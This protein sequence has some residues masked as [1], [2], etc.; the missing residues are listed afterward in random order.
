MNRLTDLHLDETNTNNMGAEVNL[1][2]FPAYLPTQTQMQWFSPFCPPPLKRERCITTDDFEIIST[3]GT[4][5]KSKVV[6]ARDISTGMDLAIKIYDKAKLTD[7]ERIQIQREIAIQGNIE[8]ENILPLYF[9]FEDASTLR[10]G[11]PLASSDLFDVLKKRGCFA[12]P[13]A[14]SV[15]AQIVNALEA[16]HAQHIMHRC[17]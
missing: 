2:A 3:L 5:C 4:G 14:R 15:V 17:G 9:A 13:M 16:C 12:E 6:H 11:L 1:I 8:H 10:I 7:I